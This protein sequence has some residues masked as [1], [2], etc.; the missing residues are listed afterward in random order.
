MEIRAAKAGDEKGMINLFKK[1]DSESKFMMMEP[2]ER[3]ISEEEQANRIKS[4][5]ESAEK[6]L[7]VAIVNSKVVGFII[8]YCGHANRTR[9]SAYMVIGVEKAYWRKGVGRSLIEFMENWAKASY[10]HRIELTVVESNLA[11]RALYKKCGYIEEGVKR[12][13]LKVDGSYVNEIYM[14]KL[15]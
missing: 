7:A 6:L 5:S 3:K 8:A 1:L 12:D 14:A 11:A 13:S 9:H 4:F 2:G 15:I 10:V